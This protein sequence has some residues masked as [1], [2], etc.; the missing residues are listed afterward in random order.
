MKTIPATVVPSKMVMDLLKVITE[1][2]TVCD[3]YMLPIVDIRF[4][5]DI[6]LTSVMGIEITNYKDSADNIGFES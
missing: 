5:G 3:E 6:G 1:L 2:R 4:N